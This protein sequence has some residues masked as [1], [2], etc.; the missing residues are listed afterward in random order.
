MIFYGLFIV[1]GASLSGPMG[2]ARSARRAI[3]PILER[4][5]VSYSILALILILL[6]VRSPTPG[7]QRLPT[8]LLLIVLLVVGFEFLRHRAIS[9]FPDQ[10]WEAGVERW[11]RGLQSA[12]SRR[13]GSDPGDA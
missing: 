13:G 3:T 9:D 11:Q 1:I 7:F 4:R 2:I 8:A 10:T 12:F 5:I 6:F